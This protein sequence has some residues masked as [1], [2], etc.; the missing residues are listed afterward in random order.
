[1]NKNKAHSEEYFTD[2]RNFWWNQDFLE[3]LSK[4]CRF[5]TVHKVLDV[6]AGQGHWTQALF[7]F[8]PSDAELTAVE[9]EERSRNIGDERLKGRVKFV[10]GTAEKLPFPDA[11]FDM[12]TCQT[13]LIHVAD[14]LIAIKEMLRVLKPG[15]LI[16]AVEPNN[17]FRELVRDSISYK[18]SLD[19]HMK[20][21]K[22]LLQCYQGH[23][24]E[25]KGERNR[26]DFLVQYF[27][28]S[29]IQE[30]SSCLSDKSSPLYPPYE[31]EEQKAIIKALKEAYESR[32]YYWTEEETRRFFLAGGGTEKEFQ[33]NWARFKKHLADIL[34]DIEKGEYYDPGTC[35]MYIVWGRKQK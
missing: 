23:A 12:I 30:V 7:P 2:S 21:L 5:N 29:G 33:E 34:E 18:R 16:L 14:P 32:Q 4:R 28:K 26:G 25:G 6:G 31:K 10:N 13:V 22:F 17:L 9:P 35:L 8:L 15:G 3:L 1:M 11:S 20:N 19:E 27:V 24:S